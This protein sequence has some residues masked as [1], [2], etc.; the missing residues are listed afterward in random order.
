MASKSLL[1]GAL[2]LLP[3]L[4]L[5]PVRSG[6]RDDM[7]GHSSSGTEVGSSSNSS[8]SCH[9][10]NGHVQPD[11]YPCGN[12]PS[13]CCPDTSLCMSNGLCFAI[14]GL[15]HGRHSCTDSSWQSDTCPKMCLG[16]GK[17]L[18]PFTVSCLASSNVY[19]TFQEALI[20]IKPST[21]AAEWIFSRR[22][23]RTYGAVIRI[24]M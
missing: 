14:Q 22:A 7:S 3:I 10:P 24:Q 18:C 9:F 19:K 1:G 5:K 15:E 12:H 2:Q 6:L 11:A 23:S 21:I 17:P 20:I 8:V 13:P 4:L 16:D